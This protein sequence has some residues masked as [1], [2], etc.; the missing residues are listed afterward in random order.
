MDRAIPVPAI[1]LED[2]VAL[3]CALDGRNTR[4]HP[5]EALMSGGDFVVA[6]FLEQSCG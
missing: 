1:A 6:N 3:L 2:K 5:R 4:L